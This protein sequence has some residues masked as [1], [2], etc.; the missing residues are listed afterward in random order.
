MDKVADAE[1]RNEVKEIALKIN[2][3]AYKME[4]KYS[5]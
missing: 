5:S 4:E 2:E 3:I 1:A